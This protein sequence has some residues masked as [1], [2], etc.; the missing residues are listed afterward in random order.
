MDSRLMAIVERRAAAAGAE[1]AAAS[2]QRAHGAL[3]AR[4]RIALL[5]DDEEFV[6]WGP[7]AG[8]ELDPAPPHGDGV[9]AGIG[10]V[11]GRAAVIISYDVTVLSGTQGPINHAKAG[12]AIDVATQLRAP[13][14]LLAEGG[15]IRADGYPHYEE[16][17]DQLF[18]FVRLSGR[19]PLIGVALGAVYSTRA[20]LLSCCDVV[21][22]TRAASVDLSD[23]AAVP[24][25]DAQAHERSGMLDL[26]LD[27]DSSAIAAAREYAR[28]MLCARVP[29]DLHEDPGGAEQLRAIVPEN[30]R[31]AF[32]AEKLVGLLA[33]PGTAMI[34]RR[35]YG[36]AI[37][38]ALG[39]VGGRTVGFLAN[40]P[41]RVAGAID[42]PA[43]DKMTRF[44]RVCDTHGLPLIYLMDT[45]G[46]LAGPAGERSAM[47]RHSTRP[48]FALH[49]LRVAVISI[50][51]RRSYGQG[52]PVMGMTGG[53]HKPLLQ[54]L[55]PTAEYGGMGLGG[56]ASITSSASSRGADDPSSAA[57]IKQA[58]VEH[59][60]AENRARRFETDDVIDPG[61]TQTILRRAVALIP[62]YPVLEPR[63]PIDAV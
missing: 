62:E 41:M 54:V 19:V 36:Q 8:A 32:D 34:L 29:W 56:A 52:G 57:E 20:L 46:L 53:I 4:A 14:F 15:G 45:P 35:R 55:W 58:L 61:E 49:A 24:P 7:Q 5:V 21:I 2:A 9:I 39:R 60:S 44:I 59:G 51:V 16:H 13:V 27:D 42:S 18:E 33:D 12:K 11:H 22:G 50:T 40:N 43:S 63:W 10:T 25:D 30:P 17:V 23:P 28:F 48:Y 38:T 26:V 31:R 37:V 47:A 6:E 1:S 3:G